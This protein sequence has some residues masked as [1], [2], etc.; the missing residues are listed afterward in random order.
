MREAIEDA[1][2]ATARFIFRVII[3]DFV[4]FHL[5]RTVL[6]IGTLGRYP[7]RRDCEQARGRIRWIG[8]VMLIV[9]WV[10]VALFNNLLA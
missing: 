1:V 10:A 9:L 5:G 6:L 3:W 2:G 8:I 7:T 4:L